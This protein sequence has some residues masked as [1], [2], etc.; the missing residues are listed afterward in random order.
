MCSRLFTELMRVKHPERI[1]KSLR[2]S[3]KTSDPVKKRAKDPNRQF[4][5]EDAQRADE[6]TKRCSASLVIREM[7]TR[8][9]RRDHF[10]PQDGSHPEKGGCA[11]VRTWSRQTSHAAVGWTS[12]S[13]KLRVELPCNSTPG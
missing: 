5:R 12:T 13:S 6:P 3:S 1:R 11:M 10:T 7:Q 2:L 9:T 4:S 8:T